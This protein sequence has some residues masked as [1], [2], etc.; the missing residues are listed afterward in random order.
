MAKTRLK[1]I[2][3][4]KERKSCG[5][6]AVYLSY[7]QHAGMLWIDK[8]NRIIDRF[9]PYYCIND[10]SHQRYIDV[11]LKEFFKQMIPDFQ[12]VGNTLKPSQAIQKIRSSKRKNSDNFCQDYGILYA[13]RRIHGMSNS[14]A[15]EHLVS[16]KND[17]LNDIRELYTQFWL[18]SR[19]L[20]KK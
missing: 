16:M 17:L 14:Q 11:A 4:M 15:A 5:S 10:E 3:N 19:T 18:F 13:I 2:L 1:S 7:K 20:P 12:Y 8:Q 9:D 6:L